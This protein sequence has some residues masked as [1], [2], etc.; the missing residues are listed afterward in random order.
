MK[1]G[2]TGRSTA[3]GFIGSSTF[4]SFKDKVVLCGHARHGIAQSKRRDRRFGRS[5]LPTGGLFRAF[6]LAGLIS[7]A[8][9]N[10]DGRRRQLLD[11][12]PK[13]AG[14][15]CRH[16]LG[17][18]RKQPQH[19]G[20][21]LHRHQRGTPRAMSAPGGACRTAGSR[22]DGDRIV[23][24]HSS[25]LPS[26]CSSPHAGKLEAR[27]EGYLYWF[28]EISNRCG[29]SKTSGRRWKGKPRGRERDD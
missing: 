13:R 26:S 2:R 5:F 20:L 10:A 6:P 18:F 21:A 19:G 8:I 16:A 29:F 27:D 25:S 7:K 22:F 9:Q 1:Y 12:I 3:Q 23:Q 15:E 17:L 28:N 11:A 4:N 14:E 24:V